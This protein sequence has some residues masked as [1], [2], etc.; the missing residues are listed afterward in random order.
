MES[1]YVAVLPPKLHS[2]LAAYLS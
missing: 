2:L 1:D